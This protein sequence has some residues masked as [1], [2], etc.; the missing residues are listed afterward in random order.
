MDADQLRKAIVRPALGLIGVTSGENLVMGT[1]AQESQLK[2][3][4]QLGS[5]PALG[6]YQM[7]PAT[8]KDIW[9]NYLSYREELA[10]KILDSI[11]ATMIPTAERLI[12]D[13]RF[14]TIMCRVHYR[15]VAE[16]L[17]DEN[18]IP[19]MAQYWKTHYNTELGAGTVEEFIHNYALV[20]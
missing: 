7:E 8:Y 2:Y 9:D 17:P 11:D 4:K 13:F 15:R 19:G 5:G 10:T 20:N 18:D 14:A 1:A 16:P 6:I 3:V 12:W